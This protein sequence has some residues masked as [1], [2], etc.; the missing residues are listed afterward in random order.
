MYNPGEDDSEIDRLS[1]EAASGYKAP[2]Q[3]DWDAMME[4]LDK[5]MPQ[6]GKKRR[7]VL[8]W[9][10]AGLLIGGA[11]YFVITDGVLQPGTI[12]SGTQAVLPPPAPKHKQREAVPA[13]TP[14]PA[15]PVTEVTGR[16]QVITAT[17]K[18]GPPSHGVGHALYRQELKSLP[19]TVKISDTGNAEK[20]LTITPEVSHADEPAM[21]STVTIS[22]DQPQQIETKQVLPETIADSTTETAIITSKKRNK[23]KAWS[24]GVLGAVDESTIKF[25]YGY[26]PGYGI[27]L[28]AGYHF[29]KTVALFTGAVYTQKN[30]KMDGRDFTAPKGSWASY[31]KLE[32]VE[33]YCRMWEIPLLARFYTLHTDKKGFFLSTGISSYFMN[34][35]KYTYG[36]HLMGRPATRTFDY[37]SSTHHVFSIAHVS[38]GF[39]SRV[40][41]HLYLQIEPYAK[42]PLGGVGT[43]KIELSSFGMNLGIQ[44]RKPRN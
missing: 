44:F 1:R 4:R 32:T 7:P 5:E 24:I 30:Y 16:G 19:G 3:P 29:N 23:A 20:G 17:H 41:K 35:E 8:F 15:K 42:I 36:Y 39:E 14:S 37:A 6:D 26:E 33:G 27:G 21:V 10:L 18:Q 9:L 31:Y 38:A 40:G 28:L 2:G 25:K 34:Y 22:S 12:R 13:Y 43:G 11:T